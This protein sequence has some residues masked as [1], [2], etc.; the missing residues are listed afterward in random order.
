MEFSFQDDLKVK[1]EKLVDQ[2]EEAKKLR[3]N[4]EKKSSNVSKI[5]QKYLTAEQFSDYKAFIANKTRL[6]VQTRVNNDKISSL[7]EQLRAVQDL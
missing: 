3:V 5:L 1:R 4:I 7:S 2:L 6:I